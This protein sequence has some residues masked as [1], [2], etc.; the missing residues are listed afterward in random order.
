MKKKIL[1]FLGLLGLILIAIFY[2]YVKPE[3]KKIA[4]KTSD[5]KVVPKGIPAAIAYD[6]K[7]EDSTIVTATRFHPTGDSIAFLRLWGKRVKVSE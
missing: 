6:Y 5:M 3:Y 2:F 7:L 1:P 4:Y